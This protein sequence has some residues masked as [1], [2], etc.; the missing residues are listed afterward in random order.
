MRY[1]LKLWGYVSLDLSKFSFGYDV[2]IFWAQFLVQ[3]MDPT[4]I[5]SL[6]R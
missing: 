5:K 6:T 2:K 1:K 3:Y 4:G